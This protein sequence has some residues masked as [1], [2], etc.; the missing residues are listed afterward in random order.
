MNPALTQKLGFYIQKTNVK[1]QKI[2]DSAF[3]I[4]KMVIA[5]F[6]GEDKVGKPRFF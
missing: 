1:A 5:N 3:K 6:Q 4:F 2:D